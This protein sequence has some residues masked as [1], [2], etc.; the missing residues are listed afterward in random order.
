VQT[1]GGSADIFI[2]GN[3][4]EDIPQ[5][6][7]NAGGSTGTPY[8]RPLNA[9][10]EGSRI[11]MVANTFLRTGSAPVAFVGCDTC[12]FANNTIIEPQN[13]V[14]RILEENTNRTASHDGFFINNLLVFN[15][16]D[17]NNWT[18]VNI[19][20]NTQPSTYTFGWNLWYAL[21]DPAFSGPIYQGG[22]PAEVNAIVQLEPQLA[23]R[24]YG[25]YHIPIGSP[26]QGHGI[27]V[28]RGA[29][30]DY[31]QGAFASPPSIGAFEAR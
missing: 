20:A 25:D 7:I 12:V 26:A 28:P 3:R 29:I 15:T 4:F 30:A 10:Y 2:H 9:V 14:A 18:F 17:I 6:A 23:D 21:D 27:E 19:G 5:R 24:I 11:Q 22:L 1:K 8:F 31:D 16:A 13:Y